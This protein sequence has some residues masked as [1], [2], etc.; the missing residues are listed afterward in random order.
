MINELNFIEELKNKNPLALEFVLSTFGNFMYRVAYK[1]TNSKELSEECLNDALL[2]I[3]NSI[4]NY[5][6]SDD[7]FKNWITTIVKYTAIDKF[8]AE[9]K[10]TLKTNL[11]TTIIPSTDNLEENQISK[12][13]LSLIK[14]YISNLN[15]LDRN[16]ITY[17]FFKNSTVK[18][19]ASLYNLSENA[20][21][22]RIMR[23]RKKLKLYINDME[24]QNEK[25]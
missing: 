20:V 2:K 17:R 5:T 22:I 16:I 14:K 11:E 18:E 8:R 12:D 7:K 1:Y 4:D 6:Y 13:E 23:I 15:E 24:V 19:I 9:K 3:W 25:I 10:H 21:N